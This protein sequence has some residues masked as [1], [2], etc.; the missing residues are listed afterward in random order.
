MWGSV[1]MLTIP[2]SCTS[3]INCKPWRKAATAALF[4]APLIM[5]SVGTLE[6]NHELHKV[7][8]HFFNVNSDVCCGGGKPKLEQNSPSLA[9]IRQELVPVTRNWQNKSQSAHHCPIVTGVQKKSVYVSKDS[10]A[11]HVLLQNKAWPRRMELFGTESHVLGSF[12]IASGT[13]NINWQHLIELIITILSN[14]CSCNL[15]PHSFRPSSKVFPSDKH[16]LYKLK[17]ILDDEVLSSV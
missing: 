14:C 4:A 9:R 10:I 12:S 16:L 2:M 8:N 11:G 7:V 6:L 17:T 3:T 13:K 1:F 5:A 15:A